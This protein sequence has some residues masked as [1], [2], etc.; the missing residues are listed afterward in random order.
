MHLPQVLFLAAFLTFY[1][2]PILISQNLR[3]CA[4]EGKKITISLLK[5]FTQGSKYSIK[6]LLEM[7]INSAA[8]FSMSLDAWTAAHLR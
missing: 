5:G 8:M 4:L 1:Y 6:G 7:L 2:T 3:N